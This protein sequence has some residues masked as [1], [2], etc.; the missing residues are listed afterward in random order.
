ADF[1]PLHPVAAAGDVDRRI[2]FAADQVAGAGLGAADEVV[3]AAA[4]ERVTEADAYCLVSQGDG[5]GDIGADVVALDAVVVAENIDG[6]IDDATSGNDVAGFGRCAAEQVVMASD[7]DPAAKTQ[8]M[9]PRYIR[10]DEVSLDDHFARVGAADIDYS[11]DDV[12]GPRCR[13]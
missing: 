1:V 7:R 13:A 8:P 4:E 11:N 3:V 2:A 6:G 10:A 5:A 9:R 12:A